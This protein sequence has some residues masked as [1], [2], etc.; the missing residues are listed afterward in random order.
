MRKYKEHLKDLGVG[1][2]ITSTWILKETGWEGLD[3]ILLAQDKD[4]HCNAQT[5]VL[6][7]WVSYNPWNFYI[8]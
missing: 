3:W 4:L 5:M 6:N 2:S 7:L 1:G 8:R